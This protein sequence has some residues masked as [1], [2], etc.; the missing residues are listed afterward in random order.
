M[1]PG[2]F[3]EGIGSLNVKDGRWGCPVGGP[4]IGVSENAEEAG[5][6]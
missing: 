6:A 3:R 2:W 4:D 5:D 1:P